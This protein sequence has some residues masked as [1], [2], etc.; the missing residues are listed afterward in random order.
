MAKFQELIQR[1][2]NLW[3]DAPADIK[4]LADIITNG[5]IMQDYTAQEHPVKDLPK[6]PLRFHSAPL[7]KGTANPY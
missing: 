7:L 4:A 5:K 2:A 1:G 6:D 3:P